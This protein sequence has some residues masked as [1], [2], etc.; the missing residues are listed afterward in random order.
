MTVEIIIT[1]QIPYLKEV[2]RRKVIDDEGKQRF[3]INYVIGTNQHHWTLD[4]HLLTLLD[5]EC[6]TLHSIVPVLL[7]LPQ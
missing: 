7:P 2:G 6:K 1:K 5:L 4:R 3:N